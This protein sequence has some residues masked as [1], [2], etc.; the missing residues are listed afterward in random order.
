V[1]KIAK[2][3][4]LNRPDLHVGTEGEFA[5][6][7]TWTRDAFETQSGPFWHRMEHDGRIRCAF[8][9]EKKHLNGVKNVHGGCFMS[10]ADYCLFATA[11]PILEGP[12]V[13]LSFACEFL[14]AAREGDLVEGVAEITRVGKSIIFLRGMLS[15]AGR[16][17]LSFSASIKRVVRRHRSPTAAGT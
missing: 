16:P 4:F 9:V 2:S 8:R 5:G 11:A 1:D 12:G 3:A 10:F 6:W 13:T 7:Y 14:D 15:S 17:V